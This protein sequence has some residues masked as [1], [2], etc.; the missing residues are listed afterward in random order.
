[1]LCLLEQVLL[2][3]NVSGLSAMIMPASRAQVGRRYGQ[4]QPLL[5]RNVGRRIGDNSD[6]R[7]TIFSTL[8]CQSIL[9]LTLHFIFGV[10]V[11]R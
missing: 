2:L 3:G 8:W 10:A 7:S 4:L 6:V 1:M 9:T 5:V 11:W